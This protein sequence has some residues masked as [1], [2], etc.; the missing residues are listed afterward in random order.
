MSQT[1][2]PAKPEVKSWGD[3]AT[4]F[5]LSAYPAAEKLNQQLEALIL[6][7]EAEGPQN[8]N[9]H[10]NRHVTSN[11]VNI[12]ESHFDIF[13]DP[14]AP[15]CILE[16]KKFF[17]FGIFHA[18][19]ETSGYSKEELEQ[20]RVFTD[21]WYHVTHN[22]GFISSHNHPNASWSAVYM[23]NP[24]NSGENDPRN[25][26]L[27]FKDPRPTANMYWDPGNDRWQRQFHIG[28][29]NQPMQPGELLVF[30]SFVLHEVMPYFGDKPRI[31]VAA[32]CSFKR[33]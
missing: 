23:V 3:F 10:A 2:P 26:V 31:T 11:Q 32:N 1:A 22:G 30:P 6:Q 16:L 33:V 7:Q 17:L 19:A 13:K 25:G 9:R 29:V 28:S 4:P 5:Y 14:A 8:T 21:A 15:A 24:G 18:M 20:I 12:F 27:S